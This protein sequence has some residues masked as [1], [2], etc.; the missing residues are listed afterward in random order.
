MSAPLLGKH[1]Q[2]KI[3]IQAQNRVIHELLR[4]KCTVCAILLIMLNPEFITATQTHV[5]FHSH[6][7]IRSVYQV[8]INYRQPLQS[9]YTVLFQGIIVQGKNVLTSMHCATSPVVFVNQHTLLWVC[10]VQK[11]GVLDYSFSKKACQ[12]CRFIPLRKTPNSGK[13]LNRW[14][15]YFKTPD[16]CF[17]DSRTLTAISSGFPNHLNCS[18]IIKAS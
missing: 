7:F 11:W 12:H 3:K 4:L 10:V 14:Q 8:Y 17:F 18:I 16:T 6:D 1:V 15:P 5:A 13:C 2:P 9:T